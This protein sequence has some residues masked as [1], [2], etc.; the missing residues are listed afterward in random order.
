MLSGPDID[1]VSYLP[2]GTFV[3][4]VLIW[5]TG[6]SRLTLSLIFSSHL[7]TVCMWKTFLHAAK[8]VSWTFVLSHSFSFT[9][10]ERAQSL[11]W[12]PHLGDKA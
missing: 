6:D 1:G 10:P 9:F 4:P 8:G 2:C 12:F 3:S 5:L 11:P 7:P